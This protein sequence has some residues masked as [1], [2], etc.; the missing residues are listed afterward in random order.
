[1]TVGIGGAGCK[2]AA[3]LDDDAVLVKYPRRNW[4]KS[5]RRASDSCRPG[6][7]AG[8]FKVTEGS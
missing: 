8:G 4:A 5:W 7:P 1:M 3:K 2:I 6:V